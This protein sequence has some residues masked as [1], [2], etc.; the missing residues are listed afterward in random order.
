MYDK[1]ELLQSIFEVENVATKL[2]GCITFNSDILLNAICKPAYRLTEELECS[3]NVVGKWLSRAFPDRPKTSAKLDVYLLRKYGYKECKKCTKVFDLDTDHFHNNKATADKFSNY[4]KACMNTVTAVTSADR[5]AR[6]KASKLQRTPKWLSEAELANIS[7]FYNGC[8]VGYHVD[9]IIPLQGDL[10]S[11]LHV[12]S[13]LQYLTV[14]EN[15]SKQNKF[16]PG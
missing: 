5:Q 9:H 11:G 12:L 2:T 10:V 8:P 6:Y 15:C 13:N 3:N 1:Y 4:C 14:S 7:K 16:T